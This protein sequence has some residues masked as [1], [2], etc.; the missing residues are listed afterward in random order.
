MLS[1]NQRVVPLYYQV[2]H[3]LSA[4]IW[5][6]EY[7]PG[8]QLPSESEFSRTLAV[9]RVTVR[10]ALR[11]LTD[12]RL[13]VK[14][15]G[16]G[17]F[18]ADPLPQVPGERR[19]AG[20]LEDLYDQLPRVT[21]RHLEIAHVTVTGEIRRALELP[22]AEVTVVRIKRAR[23]VDDAPYT[24]T[25]NLLPLAV[26]ERLEAELLRRMPIVRVLEDVLQIDIGGASEVF[27]AAA[28]DTEIAHWLEVPVLSPVMHVRRSLY[29]AAGRPL[30]IASSY[31]RADKVE[32]SVQLVRARN[33][34]RGSWTEQGK[35]DG[36]GQVLKI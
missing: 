21:V 20:Y 30:Q 29:D 24:F 11:V 19:F 4:R 23:F 36:V 10:E 2:Q 14:T 28:A 16:K 33:N 35:T 26:G 22:D 8:S 1:R 17:T 15:Q 3:T 13:V 34:G 32:Y 5:S 18:V 9:S 27:Q 7:P 25:V 6:G 31:Y 12:E